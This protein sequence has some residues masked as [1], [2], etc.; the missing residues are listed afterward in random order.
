[1]KEIKPHSTHKATCSVAVRS[2]AHMLHMYEYLL[3]FPHQDGVRG[4][5]GDLVVGFVAAGEAEVEVFYL[6]VN[7]RV[8]QLGLNV[9]PA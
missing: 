7:V 8:N 6:E 5:D 3:R 4:V 2:L 9:I 1:M